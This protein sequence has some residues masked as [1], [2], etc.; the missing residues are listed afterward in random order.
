MK[1]RIFYILALFTCLFG[2]FTSALAQGD[3]T[4]ENPF[5]MEN[6]GKYPIKMYNDF[7]GKFI[8]PEDVTE[9]GITLSLKSNNVF[10]IYTDAN[11][12]KLVSTV[13]GN[14]SPYTTLTTVRKGTKKGTVYYIYCSFPMNGGD[15]EV[16]YGKAVPVE[17][18]EVIPA[19]GSEL[20]A[21]ESYVGFE[22]TKAIF[23]EGCIIK[24]GETEKEVE[25]HINDRFVSIEAKKEML[26]LYNSGALKKGEEI[27]FI[28]KNVTSADGKDKLGNVTAKYIAA[29]KPTMVI[30]E[31]STP[32]NGMDVLKSWLPTEST[33][34]LVKITFNEALNPKATITATLTYGD[35]ESEDANGY[36]TENLTTT[37]EQD[38]ILCIDLRGK[39]RTPATM[40]ASGKIYPTAML[41]IKGVEDIN[42]YMTLSEE[43]G[44]AGSYF[45]NYT[46]ELIEYNMMTE[47]TPASGAS[48]DG[49]KEIEIWMQ[50]TGGN[51][52]FDG[53]KFEYTYQNEPAEIVISKDKLS[54]ETDP[55]DETASIIL[56]TVPEFERDADCEVKLSLTG[57]IS[58]DGIAHDEYLTAV[59]TT[60]GIP[61]TSG[62]SNVA[63][64]TKSNTIY[65]IDGKKVP[66][67]YLK[68]NTKQATP[69]K[70]YILNGK[71]VV[72]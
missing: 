57:I 58:P 22:F 56:I 30:K 26:E 66:A 11:M 19:A 48:I 64:A 54:V 70:I 28:L 60:K 13:E 61:D 44:N 55:E 14:F 39:L 31:E 47:F 21:A 45:Y 51:I 29:Q 25:A 68:D 32:G 42:G 67:N 63:T 16:T 40:V 17:L 71:K 59:Y 43:L 37:I 53:V 41:M 3:G 5:I 7:Y 49:V 8:V 34:G 4:A 46:Y 15:V 10:D 23:A 24:V 50:E 33:T 36:Y 69:H 65:T 12:T 72:R 20:S 38:S 18:K 35:M 27:T 52:T 1:L 2:H 9:E 62:I 6:G